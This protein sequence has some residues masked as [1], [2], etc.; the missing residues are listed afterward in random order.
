[1]GICMSNSPFLCKWPAMM[2]VE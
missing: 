2:M 1:M